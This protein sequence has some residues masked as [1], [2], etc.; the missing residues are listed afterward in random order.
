MLVKHALGQHLSCTMAMLRA[1]AHVKAAV[2][3][4][5]TALHLPA[6]KPSSQVLTSKDASSGQSRK[7]EEIMQR[8]NMSVLQDI[9]GMLAV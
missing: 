1:S 5:G 6:R 8:R 3:L 7:S 9:A 2:C 4:A